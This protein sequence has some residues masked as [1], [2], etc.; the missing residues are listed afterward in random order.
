M[1][2]SDAARISTRTRSPSAPVPPRSNP[3]VAPVSESVTEV[4]PASAEAIV[5]VLKAGRLS[6]GTGLATLGTAVLTGTAEGS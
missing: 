6:R 3:I 4:P 2:I 1:A 5:G